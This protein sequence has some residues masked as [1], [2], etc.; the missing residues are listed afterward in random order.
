[1]GELM[2]GDIELMEGDLTL[3]DDITNQKYLKV[4][5]HKS[6]V[7]VKLQLHDAIYWL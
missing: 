2:R 7:I 3:I 5:Y 6:E 4:L 1:M